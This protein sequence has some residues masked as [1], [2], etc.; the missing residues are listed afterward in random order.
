METQKKIH[1]THL[2]IL[3]IICIYGIVYSHSG[4]DAMYMYEQVEGLGHWV[5]F[6]IKEIVQCFPFLFFMMSGGLLLKKEEDIKTLF[7]KRIVRYLVII[8]VFSLFQRLY[9]AV[10]S[11][12]FSQFSLVGSFKAMYSSSVIAQYWFLYAYLGMLLI[13]PFLRMI[14]AKLTKETAVYLLVLWG[15]FKTVLPLFEKV[16][17]LDP[18]NITLDIFGIGF[19]A[20]LVGY[21]VEYTLYEFFEVRKNRVLIYITGVVTMALDIAYAH[22]TYQNTGNIVTID[23]G[24]ILGA[25]ALYVFVLQ[26]C[27]GNSFKKPMATVLQIGGDGIMLVYLLE[28]QLRSWFRFIYMGLKPYITWFP[29]ALIWFL[30][31]EIA[32]IVMAFIL[33]KIPGVKK[34]I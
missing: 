32:G 7:K 18:I 2:D 33:H 4:S 14:A 16:T 22:R 19:I 30:A 13:L 24:Y 15:V 29:A 3:R 9:W 31:A 11:D 23:G 28:P 27:K 1:K 26:A 20:P 8:V 17:K 5:G 21:S 34:F 12:A 6:L 10:A 25:L